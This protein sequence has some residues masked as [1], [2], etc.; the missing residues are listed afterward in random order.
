MDQIIGQLSRSMAE[1][2]WGITGTSQKRRR[3]EDSKSSVLERISVACSSSAR[4]RMNQAFITNLPSMVRAMYSMQYCIS[5]PSYNDDMIMDDVPGQYEASCFFGAN[6]LRFYQPNMCAGVNS[7]STS[8]Q[9]VTVNDPKRGGFATRVP[10]KP[11]CASN[12][13][14]PQHDIRTVKA[15]TA[16][17]HEY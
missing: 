13:W 9:C 15:R 11:P 8:G 3:D 7:F 10:V 12:A 4:E 1:Y 2:K 6:K 16:Q 17:W 5:Q 14:R